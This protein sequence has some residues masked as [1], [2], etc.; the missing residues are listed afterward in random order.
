MFKQNYSITA[1]KILLK[2][3]RYYVTITVSDKKKWRISKCLLFYLSYNCIAVFCKMIILI[4][5]LRGSY[6]ISKGV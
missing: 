3:K 6:F 1:K 4:G 5:R 2:F